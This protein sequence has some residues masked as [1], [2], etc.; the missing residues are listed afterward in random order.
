VAVRYEVVAS[1]PSGKERVHTYSSDTELTPGDVIRLAGRD[2]LV[3][4]SQDGQPPR[5]SA[6]PARYRLR[7]RR[8][9]GKDELGAFRRF[10]PDAPKVGHGFT[11]IEDG[12]PASWQVVEEILAKDEEGEPYLEL[13]AERDFGEFDELPDHELEH[14]VGLQEP[15]AS[16][17]ATAL[18]RAEEAGLAVELVALEAGEEADWAAAESYIDALIIEEIEDD[19][20]ELA[21]VKPNKDPKETWLETVQERLRADLA[22][23]RN[24]AEGDRAEIQRWEF[25]DGRVYASVGTME[26]ESDPDSG[27]GWMCRLL[28]ASALGAAGFERVR[29]AQL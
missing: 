21:G 10:R 7:L 16:E 28:D 19:L 4:S 23:F 8:P 17:A 25:R 14:A 26:D 22:H 27:H 12:A 5:L 1:T 2:W 15:G 9:D 20:L 13:I 11:T 29:K 3:H 24:D 6:R 18:A